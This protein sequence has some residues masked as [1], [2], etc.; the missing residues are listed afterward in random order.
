LFEQGNLGHR[1]LCLGNL[2]F[3]L[4]DSGYCLKAKVSVVI[5]YLFLFACRSERG[6]N[7]VRHNLSFSVTCHFDLL[8]DINV[9][10]FLFLVIRKDGPEKG[11]HMLSL[12]AVL[13]QV[14]WKN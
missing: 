2:L 10:S 14:V 13:Y 9:S 8:E 12:S 3:G 11:N 5:I 7:N 6:D 4:V 1:L